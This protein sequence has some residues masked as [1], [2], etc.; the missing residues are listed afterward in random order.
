MPYAHETDYY[1][2]FY[3]LYLENENLMADIDQTSTC[4]FQMER[5]ILNILDFY[6]ST[7]IPAIAHEPQK[8]LH[9]KQ[10]IKL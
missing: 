5:R 6:D 9:R 8:F 7:L 3:K 1:K 2:E 10:M 4:N